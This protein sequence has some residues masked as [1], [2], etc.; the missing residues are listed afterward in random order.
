MSSMSSKNSNAPL[1]SIIVPVFR[2]EE[3]LDQCIQSILS[4]TYPHLEIILVDDGSP[5]DCPRLCDEYAALDERVNVMHK[6][7]GGS[8]SAREAGMS[9]AT[10]NYIMFI[11][12]DDWI[13][14]DTVAYCIDVAC[15]AQAGCVLFSYIKEYPDKSIKTTLF[16]SDFSYDEADSEAKVHRRLVGLIGEELRHPEKIDNISSVCMKLY[17][18]DVARKGRT[19][20]ERIVGTSED[21]IFNLYALDGCQISYINRCFYHYRK[22]NSQSITTHH[23]ADLAEKWDVMY[24]IFQ[25]YIDSSGRT[26]K[27]RPAFFNRVACSMIGLGLNEINSTNNI[28]HKAKKLRQILNRPLYIQA[29]AQLDI[30]YCPLKWKVFFLLCKC[31]LALLL[32][33]LLQIINF[34]RSRMA[35]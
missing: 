15:K 34:L 33:A 16:D 26:E 12:S 7:N 18:I 14:P 28:L 20:S 30:S 35:A 9:V 10:G 5:D 23:K 8:S 19:I 17:D 6:D 31:K 32:A 11:D 24:Q 29:F 2:T 1:V 22:T 27:Y 4:Q 25:E 3:F 13:E 21:T